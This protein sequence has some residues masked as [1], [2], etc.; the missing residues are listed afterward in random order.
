VYAFG[1]IE[2]RF[3]SL[4]IEKEFAQATARAE[5]ID[6]TDHETLGAV[7]SDKQNRYLVRQLCWVLNVD[8]VATYLLLPREESDLDLLIGS[9]RPRPLPSDV[10]VIV[11]VRGPTRSCNELTLPTVIFD[12]L[13]SFDLDTLVKSIQP[14]DETTATNFEAAAESLFMRVMHLAGNVG[15]TDEHRAVNYLAIRYPAIY[16]MTAEAHARNL[17]FVGL[18][19]RSSH[20]DSVRKI[21]E[22]IFAYRNRQTDI[23]EKYFVRVD[24]TEEFP[25]LVTKLSSFYE[26]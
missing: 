20:R 11:G 7:L 5:T 2:P 3:P 8:G 12:Q 10:D 17:S 18:K 23:T 24:V 6:L 15:E 22:V 4:S 25:F 16:T 13:Y 19:T 1:R 21:A 9:L 14:P 26:M